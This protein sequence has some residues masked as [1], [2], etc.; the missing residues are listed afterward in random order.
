MAGP[1]RAKSGARSTAQLCGQGSCRGFKWI[2]R[3][4]RHE[5]DPSPNGWA[6][7]GVDR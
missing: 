5:S 7:A 6:S 2:D 3:R 4:T 1:R